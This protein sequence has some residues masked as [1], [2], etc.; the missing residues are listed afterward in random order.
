[1]PDTEDPSRDAVDVEEP[2]TVVDLAESE[3]HE[4][5]DEYMERVLTV[6]EGIS[7]ARDDVDVEFAVSIPRR[8]TNPKSRR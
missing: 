1:M 6:F 3:Y 2:Q 8:N 7:D 4:L 5:A